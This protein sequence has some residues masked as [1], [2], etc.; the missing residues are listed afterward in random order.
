M[1]GFTRKQVQLRAGPQQAYYRDRYLSDLRRNSPPVFLD[2]VGPADFWP[3]ER[4]EY[5]NEAWPELN[6]WLRANYRQ[7]DDRD[8]I[9]IYVRRD[10]LG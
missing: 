8:G 1:Q 7:V 9:R 2:A 5:G 6:R 3:K 4:T 10:R